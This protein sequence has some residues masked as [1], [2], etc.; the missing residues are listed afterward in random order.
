MS[1]RWALILDGSYAVSDQGS[2]ARVHP[3]WDARHPER[4]VPYRLKLR[5][6]NAYL[7]FLPSLDGQ[8]VERLCVHVLVAHAFLGPCPPDHEVNH[9]DGDKAN[10][11][12]DNLEYLT[13]AENMQHAVRIGLPIGCKAKQQRV[14]SLALRKRS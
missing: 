14:A 6:W 3:R 11:R 8:Q 1:E 9:K 5:W 4:F 7:S 13:H 10:N 12:W 2:I